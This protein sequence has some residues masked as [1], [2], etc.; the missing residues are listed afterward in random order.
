VRRS[1]KSREQFQLTLVF[2]YG[3]Q[4]LPDLNSVKFWLCCFLAPT[5]NLI[6]SGVRPQVSRKKSRRKLRRSA[7]QD[8]VAANICPFM[9]LREYGCISKHMPSLREHHVARE[10]LAPQEPL[11]MFWC[12]VD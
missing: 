8:K 9:S 12:D 5:I 7:H 1:V 2:W 11:V 4:K 10:H 6:L 3:D